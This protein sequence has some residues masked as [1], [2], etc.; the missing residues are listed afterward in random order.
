MRGWICPAGVREGPAAARPRGPPQRGRLAGERP[1]ACV[2][3]VGGRRAR[4][5]SGRVEGRRDRG[6][7]TAASDSERERKR[8]D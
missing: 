2:Q 6:E 3:P 1:G 5:V 8:R 4:L 7:K